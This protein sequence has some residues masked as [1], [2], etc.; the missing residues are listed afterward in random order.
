MVRTPLTLSAILLAATVLAQGPEARDTTKQQDPKP[1]IRGVTISTHGSGWDWGT[2]VIDPAMVSIKK[3]GGTWAC[4]H[5][6]A[7]IARDGTVS[8][9]TRRRGG[10]GQRGR[11]GR[12]EEPQPQVQNQDVQVP[13]HW[14]RPISLTCRS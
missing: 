11:R 7:G 9:R 13:A 10:R 5:P 8:F 2:D 1:T 6:Y 14:T 3:V 12:R 4:T